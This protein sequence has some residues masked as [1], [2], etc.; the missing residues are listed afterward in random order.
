[1]APECGSGLLDQRP[2]GVLGWTRPAAEPRVAP[3]SSPPEPHDAAEVAGVVRY[4][5]APGRY[6]QTVSDGTDVT[7]AYAYDEAAGGMAYQVRAGRGDG[8]RGAPPLPGAAAIVWG[9]L[10]LI[11]PRL[12]LCLT[13]NPAPPGRAPSCTTC[14]SRA[15][16]Q[17]R[18][19]TTVWVSPIG[20]GPCYH[21][22][23]QQAA[24]ASPSPRPSHMLLGSSTWES[25]VPG[26]TVP[27]RCLPP[28]ACHAA[29]GGRHPNGTATPDGKEFSF[30]MP[31]APPAQLRVGIIGDP[32]GRLGCRE[33]AGLPDACFLCF[34]CLI[35]SVPHTCPP[36]TPMHQLSPAPLA[37]QTHNT[38]TTLQHLAASQP[39]VVL[40]LGDLSYADLY[41]SNDTSNAWSFP[42]PP[43]TQQL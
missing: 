9:R 42:S 37:G 28:P 11:P 21:H 27:H 5:E 39:D 38:S 32:G 43:S 14:C 25:A 1:M 19:T 16:R 18:R 8:A 41:F 26:P 15:S 10:R 6:T 30:A 35:T 33:A 34:L 7:Y 4:G 22:T 3:A 12:A 31:A 40:V 24:P 17:G 36:A 29:P 2:A 13:P 23:C 20:A